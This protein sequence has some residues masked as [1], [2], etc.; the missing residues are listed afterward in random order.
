MEIIYKL[1]KIKL[2]SSVITIGSYDGIHR[3]HFH[4]INK[5]NSISNQLKISSVVITFDPHPRNLIGNPKEKVKLLMS[6]EKKIELIKNMSID[7]LVILKFDTNLM[8]MDAEEFLKKILIKNFNP[9]CIVSGLNHTFGH[10][11]SGDI[12]YLN[13]FCKKNDI[14]MEVVGPLKDGEMIISSTNI[15]NLIDNGFIRRA[16]YELGSMYGFYSKVVSG[17]GRGKKLNYPTA[18]LRPVDKDQ[19]LPKIGVYFTRCIINGLSCY[20]MCNFGVRPTFE[21]SDLVL[22]VH[23]FD[24]VIYDL[25]GHCIWI[26]FLERV[27]DEIKFSSIE[28]LIKQLEKDKS[29][30]LALK[31]K[32][33]LGEEDAY[34]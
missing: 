9:K 12:K 8:N 17:S 22:E 26:E 29:N 21:E 28:K 5:V 25:Y 14:A 19:L 27:R 32:Y 11:K 33:E 13:K 20:G 16:N 3:G 24:E 4:I 15:R 30:C 34:I 31:Y 1:D 6:L 7:Y 18:N 2:K 23:L 10:N